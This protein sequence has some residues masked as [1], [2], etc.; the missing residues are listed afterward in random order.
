MERILLDD[1]LYL[2][3]AAQVVGKMISTT[4]FDTAGP[5]KDV[6]QSLLLEWNYNSFVNEMNSDFGYTLGTISEAEESVS[7]KSTIKP[8]VQELFDSNPELASIGTV[9]QYSQYLDTIF[10][11]SKV[12]DIVYHGS[13]YKFEKFDKSKLGSNT[14]PNKEFP[15]FNDSYLGF[16]FTSNPEYYRAR[17]EFGSKY[18]KNLNE[19]IAI[20]NIKNPKDI[21]DKN[22]F[23]QNDISYIK[24]EDVKNNDSI[25][26]D[27]LDKVDF[28]KGEK[29]N[30]YTNNYVVFEPEQIHILGNKKDLEGF[31]EFVKKTKKETTG[32]V[33][34]TKGTL[35]GSMIKKNKKVTNEDKKAL[36]LLNKEVS[37]EEAE[38]AKKRCK[39]E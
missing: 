34:S 22:E 33:V 6:L 26:Y 14:N 27:Y 11:D 32:K 24:S 18:E 15:Q 31:K 25:I 21:A 8:G 17:F 16:H 28:S 19:Y 23:S 36:S 5:G 4:K 12:K 7:E 2:E 30:I 38:E 10:P 3:D 39:G 37:K 1:F 29:T 20:L 35:L 13:K 9:Q